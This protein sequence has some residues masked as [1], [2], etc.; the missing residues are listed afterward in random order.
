[1]IFRQRFTDD[2]RRQIEKTQR[3]IV[4]TKMG[5]SVGNDQN[6]L[7]YGFMQKFGIKCG[8]TCNAFRNSQMTCKARKHYGWFYMQEKFRDKG[9][10]MCI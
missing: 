7:L 3:Q 4:G 10:T 9:S 1:M 6:T 2:S 5:S 8:K